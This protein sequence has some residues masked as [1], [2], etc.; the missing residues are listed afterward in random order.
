MCSVNNIVNGNESYKGNGNGNSIDNV[1]IVND[2]VFVVS[3]FSDPF[4]SAKR[5]ITNES[6]AGFSKY[7]PLAP[8][9]IKASKKSNIVYSIDL[10]I[11]MHLSL[12]YTC[13][14]CNQVIVT[15]IRTVTF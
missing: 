7:F 11:I 5:A 13:V 8:A 4:N 10:S 12:Y 15:F 2:D 9:L 6:A 14:Y 1:D 3:N